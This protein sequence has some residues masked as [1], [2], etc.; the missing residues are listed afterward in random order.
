MTSN[1]DD[2]NAILY[3]LAGVGL[4]A[5]IGAAAGLLFAPKAGSEM[6]EDLADKFKELKGKTE[7]WISEQRAKRMAAPAEEL[8]V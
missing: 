7:E 4:G 6:R 8:G 1:N 3:L 2:N 5:L